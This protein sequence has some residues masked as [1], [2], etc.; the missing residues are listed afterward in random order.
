MAS[1]CQIGSPG[2]PISLDG[3]YRP[4]TEVPTL[5]LGATAK[6]RKA[7]AAGAGPS[8]PVAGLGQPRGA[9]RRRHPRRG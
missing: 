5:G 4:Q 7:G 9:R 1:P 2:H 6:N 3:Y 8:P